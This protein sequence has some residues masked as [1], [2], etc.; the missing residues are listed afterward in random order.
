MSAVLPGQSDISTATSNRRAY[1]RSV[2][3]IGV[4]TAS[5]LAYAHS[6][7]IIHRDIKPG[8]LILDTAGNVWV[9]DFGL[10]K[11]GDGGLTHTGD[12]LGTVRYMSPERFRGHCDVRADVYGLGM[13]LYEL[14]TLQPA[15]ASG[16]RLK[17][18]ELIRQTE[19]PGPR[20][21]D[22]RIPRDLETI[23][24]KAI[25]KDPKRRYQ[26][27]DEMGDDLQR[28]VNDEP[29][30][31]RRAGSVERLGRW[32][33][34]N[35]L[36]ASLL[37]VIALVFL[38]G[39]A[40]V[41]WQWR[42]AESARALERSQRDRAERSQQATASAFAVVAAQKA[43]V[44][45]SL[46]KAEAAERQARAAEEAGRKLLYTTDM[47][48][49][50]FVWNDPRATAEQLRVLLAKHVPDSILPPSP[51]D[52]RGF[53]WQYYQHVLEHSAAV[54]PSRAGAV[55]GG[56][57]APDGQL[58]TLDQR[59]QIRRWDVDSQHEDER[60]RHDLPGGARAQFRVL[61]PDGR[62]AA[63]AEG[64]QVRLLD[65]STGKEAFSID[66][67]HHRYRGLVFSLDGDTLVIVDDKIR[68]CSAA[69]GGVIASLNQKLGPYN[70]LALSADGLT[71]AV[72]GI[73]G[74]GQKF[75][76]FRLDPTAKTVTTLAKEAGGWATKIA[77]ALSPDGRW[78]AL[79]YLG[80]SMSVFDAVTGQAASHGPAHA[81]IIRAMAFSGDGAR[82]ATADAQGTIKV[83]ADPRKLSSE[84]AAL[85]TLKGHQGTITTIRFSIDGTRLVTTS[86]D[87]TVRVWDL[88]NPDPAVRRLERF[89]GP[90]NTLARFSPDGQLIAASPGGGTAGDSVCLWDAATGRLLRDF[91]D[92]DDGDDDIYSVAFSPTDGRLLAAGV[93]RSNGSFVSLWDIDAGT[94][95]AR[96]PA[97]T[98]RPGGLLTG[99]VGALA[100]SP[101]GK[102]IVAGFGQRHITT[103]E[104]RANPLKVWEVAT[105]RPIR[106]L[107]G[108][109]GYCPSLA[110]S[111]DGAL[112][113]SGSRDGTAIIWS[114]KTWKPLRT[115]QNRDR[116]TA[117]FDDLMIDP[118]GVKPQFVECVAFAPDGKTLAMA[119]AGAT[120]QLWDVATGKLR[121]TLRG[122]S[123]AVLAVAFAPDGR[124]LASGGADQTVRLWNVET[125]R[126]LMQLDPGTVR[127][128]KVQSLDFSADGTQLLA[129]GSGAA[130]WSTVPIVW[131]DPG[132]A[133][134]KLQMLLKS[135]AD[136]Q[137]RIRML[138]EYLRLHEAVAK[139]DANDQRVQGALAATEAN[140]HASRTEWRQ[141][142]AAFDRV[143]AADPSGAN[144]WLRT[145][146]LLRLAT[147]LVHEDRPADAATL[148][149][150]CAS[151]RSADGIR[152]H[153][154]ESDPPTGELLDTLRALV[155]GRLGKD[156]RNP[157]LL[158]LR[159]ELAGLWADAKAQVADYTAAI[160][161]L[162][163]DKADAADLKRLYGR[164]GNAHLA[165]RQWQQALDD[166]AHVM[167]DATT[168]EKLLANR[169]MALAEV[170]LAPAGWTVLEPVKAESELGTTF[171]ILP[172]D[173]ILVGGAAS[174]EG[175]LPR[176]TEAPD[177]HRP[178]GAPSGGSH[179][180]LAPQSWSRAARH[181][182]VRSDVLE[183]DR[184]AAGWKKVGYSPIRQGLGRPSAPRV[185]DQGQRTLEYLGRPWNELYRGLDDAE[186]GL[187]GGR[188]DALVR[189]AMPD[190]QRCC[191][192]HRPLPRV[193]IQQPRRDRV[194][195][196]MENIHRSLAKARGRVSAQGR[197][198]SH[199]PTGRSTSEV[200]RPDRRHVHP[201]H[202]R[203]KGLA[204]RSRAVHQGDHGEDH[205]RRPAFEAGPRHEALQN[206]DAAAADW[207]RAATLGSDGPRLLAEL[208][209]RLVAGGH[210]RLAKAQ[211]DRSRTLYERSLEADP[212]NDLLAGELAQLLWDQCESA[213][214][215]QWT[216][217]N[218][219]EMKSRGG[220][221]L[222]RLDDRSILAG[223]VNP[224]SDQ[225]TVAF[226]F[227]QKIEIRRFGWK[228]SRM[229]RCRVRDPA[230]RPGPA[231]ESSSWTTGI[232][233]RMTRAVR[234]A[235]AR[236]NSTLCPPIISGSK[237]LYPWTA[238]GTTPGA[239]ARVT[240]PSGASLTRSPPSPAPCWFPR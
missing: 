113:A 18:I 147:A 236:C 232:L 121:A 24:M 68:W 133:A 26:S 124:T 194:G 27:A 169:A 131:N 87:K 235:A 98:N 176:R 103:R 105:R 160:E 170:M 205:R 36:P 200:R 60:H 149:H 45:G 167:T 12:I 53:E 163:H 211:F 239:A 77:S 15:Y 197:P 17:L 148:L 202:G 52:L 2:A 231:R 137:G 157:A 190:R 187:L 39:F 37:A 219:V 85:W 172:D 213:N 185:A 104:S 64:D 144:G 180:R 3:Q 75:S 81:A 158:E 218:P 47:R 151:R 67:A 49:A 153:V 227:P 108:H 164:R 182:R 208:A 84:S 99:A 106:L 90:L 55:D 119:S 155:N 189:D 110:F 127:L 152:P 31:A 107:E 201:R 212:E 65:T 120:V 139:L 69:N 86:T 135:N 96:L 29:V 44:E 5:A 118:Y 238:S 203:R 123:S 112:L 56:A 74:L 196:E 6:R 193:G 72:V 199:R 168:D 207:S 33:R 13:T 114:T 215:G 8:N 54:F 4:Q 209:R 43:Q 226:A 71:L 14:L 78:L 143:A 220:A 174:L 61:S 129:A 73:A 181:W 70:S 217:L 132:R 115:L 32:C 25:D 102:Y 48:L 19:A 20:S 237:L 228:R 178:E 214:A 198:E 62:L 57:F 59:G 16:D 38:A 46:S 76:T 82:L 66:S 42:V 234:G 41:L 100:F 21:I 142:A 230:A 136:F 186:A 138:S 11:T 195:V 162:A 91:R 93:G 35:P 30:T 50:P 216:A 222:T 175:P 83:W 94:E 183:R 192:K 125:R 10:A 165:L 122:H 223:G 177:R 40:G 159:H 156:P 221:T 126:E 130:V 63:L 191:R 101:D 111:R 95:L 224:P 188:H 51:A 229:I 206:W 173:S 89:R 145:P 116:G 1:C 240:A 184:H 161:A 140:W 150:E 34:R 7:G 22:R 233:R 225:F 117:D 141:A 179:A 154:G 128:G 92:T 166:Y 97:A 23:V 58:V 80:G 210:V 9:T 109:S 79:G 134:E 88:T 204:A 171:S 146:G 28:F